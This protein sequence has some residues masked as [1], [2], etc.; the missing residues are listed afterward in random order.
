MHNA[1]PQARA[2]HFK[3]LFLSACFVTQCVLIF[4]IN[5]A[6]T[7]NPTKQKCSESRSAVQGQ[8]KAS[9][10][11]TERFAAKITEFRLW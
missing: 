3:P 8:G 1:A 4:G 7:V 11:S 6:R 10:I 9:F 5:C 2:T